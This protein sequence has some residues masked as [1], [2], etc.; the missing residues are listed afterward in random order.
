LT[1]L[2]AS[3]DAQVRVLSELS[4]EDLQ[5]TIIT[6]ERA[7]VHTLIEA[8]LRSGVSLKK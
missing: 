1:D 4:D 7:Y 8:T 6:I 2:A 5:N 3:L